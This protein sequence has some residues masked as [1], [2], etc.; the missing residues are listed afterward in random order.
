[1]FWFG[2]WDVAELLPDWALAGLAFC[3][4]CYVVYE[5]LEIVRA[6]PRHSAMMDTKGD[7]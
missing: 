5:L 4:L 1:V 3:V 6:R 2:L 7:L